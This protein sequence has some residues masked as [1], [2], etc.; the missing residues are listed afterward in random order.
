MASTSMNIRVKTASSTAEHKRCIVRTAGIVRHVPVKGLRG[1]SLA[2]KQTSRRA[3]VVR[4]D[5]GLSVDEIKDKYMEYTNKIP[6]IITAGTIPVIALSLLCKQLTGSGLPAGPFG[7][8]GL[9][10]GLS[11]LVLPLGFGSLLPRLQEIASDGD[12]SKDAVLAVLQKPLPLTGRG[13]ADQRVTKL[14][15][16]VD[17]NSPMGMQLKELEQRKKEKENMSDEEKAANEALKK[18]LADQ[19]LKNYKREDMPDFE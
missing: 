8:I 1:S 3:L 12:F 16:N 4:S 5:G 19:A 17:P 15:E 11:Y 7:L 2:L 10:E 14:T 13:G 9:T 18:K 6:P